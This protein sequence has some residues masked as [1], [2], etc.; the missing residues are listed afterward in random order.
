M[1]STLVSWYVFCSA[2]PV[3][4]L[5]LP[6]FAPS[7]TLSLIWPHPVCWPFLACF[8]TVRCP[9]SF[10]IIGTDLILVSGHC[11]LTLW[12]PK[13]GSREEYLYHGRQLSAEI[14]LSSTNPASFGTGRNTDTSVLSVQHFT[15]P[16]AGSHPAPRAR[17]SPS[18]WQHNHVE[19][20][21]S[22]GM[23]HKTLLAFNVD[24][25]YVS[26][27]LGCKC[28]GKEILKLEWDEWTDVLQQ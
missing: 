24:M 13:H 7:P 10:P 3:L 26:I 1:F 11:S 2:P 5:S 21:A 18:A 15:H 27:L 17:A 19:P 8:G 28:C 25:V 23:S 9:L 20:P 12:D 14:P 16:S 22:S 6:T 4:E